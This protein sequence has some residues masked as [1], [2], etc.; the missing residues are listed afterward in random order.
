MSS[1]LDVS[2]SMLIANMNGASP[3]LV[4]DLKGPLHDVL[5]LVLL[6][7]EHRIKGPSFLLISVFESYLFVSGMQKMRMQ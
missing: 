1:K 6:E 4:V 5:H 7:T 3:S 2:S